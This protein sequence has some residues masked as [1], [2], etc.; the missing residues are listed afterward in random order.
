MG[1]GEIIFYHRTEGDGKDGEH[2][3][4]HVIT[5]DIDMVSY[6][7]IDFIDVYQT[8]YTSFFLKSFCEHLMLVISSYEIYFVIL[9]CENMNSRKGG[10]QVKKRVDR[11]V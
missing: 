5:G 9:P 10:K 11:E 2:P 6:I 8:A 4:L 7:F 3:S 1:K